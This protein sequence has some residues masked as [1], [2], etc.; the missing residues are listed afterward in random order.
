[1]EL[2]DLN[3]LKYFVAVYQ[4]SSFTAAAQRLHVTKVAVAKRLTG[5][6]KQ[7]GS[8]LFRRSTRGLSAT[9]EA[10]NLYIHA[11]ELLQHVKNFETKVSD[12]SPMDGVIRITCPYSISLAF[13]GELLVEFQKKHPGVK[14]ELISTDSIL[15]LIEHNVDL[16]LRMGNVT[17]ASLVGR[18]LGENEL[19]LCA[20]PAYLKSAPAIQNL[21]DL[22][23]HPVFYMNYHGD[24]VFK[25]VKKTL[26]DVTNTPPLAT[27]EGV[28]VKQLGMS[29]HGVIARSQWSIKEEL[30]SGKLVPVLSKFPITPM[31]PIWLLSTAGRM[32]S[33]RVK[34][35]FDMLVEKSKLYF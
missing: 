31:G 34:A 11:L 33:A 12:A 17:T 13:V 29:G 24:A 7:L 23:K 25:N 5:M 10:D 9:P 30:D 22:K 6:E 4:T 15:D 28:L 8:S 2:T 27:N 21:S 18:K 20:T 35:V 1:M 3:D 32:Q 14:F 26:R 19:I 16:A